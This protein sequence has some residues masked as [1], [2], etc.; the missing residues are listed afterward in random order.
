MRLFELPL[1]AF[2]YIVGYSLPL[3]SIALLQSSVC[4]ITAFFLGLRITVNVFLTLLVLIPVSVLFMSF[5]LLFGIIFT[6]KQVASILSSSS[7]LRQRLSGKKCRPSRVPRQW[8]HRVLEFL[9]EAHPREYPG[10][11]IL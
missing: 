8:R 9:P 2:D 1:S 11:G 6:D 5:G 7:L 4:F 3:L 10:Q